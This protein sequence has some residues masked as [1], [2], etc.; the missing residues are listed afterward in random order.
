MF[1]HNRCQRKTWLQLDIQT[2]LKFE[3]CFTTGSGTG[4]S[5]IVGR[6][7]RENGA[8][9]NAK[10]GTLSN[11]ATGSQWDNDPNQ[12]LDSFYLLRGHQIR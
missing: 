8:R 3:S 4:V 9:D 10:C 7:L 12:F 1:I 2:V 11:N 5:T 6:G